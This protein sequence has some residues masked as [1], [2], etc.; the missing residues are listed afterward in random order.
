MRGRWLALIAAA[1]AAEPRA[2]FERVDLAPYPNPFGPDQPLWSEQPHRDHPFS[3]A[4]STDGAKLYV[5]LQGVE[6]EPGREVAIVDTE[7]L[8]VVGRIGVGSS[9]TG[10]EL[11][12]GGRFLVVTNRFSNYASVI[13]T[14]SDAVAL[15][16]EAPFYTTELVFSPDGRRAWLTNRWKDSVLRWD[17]DVGDGFRVTATNYQALP[18]DGPMGIP[19]GQNPRDLAISDDGR[20]LYVA[21]LTGEAVSLI[22]TASGRETVRYDLASPPADV[23]V[24]GDA[25]FVTNIGR[26]AGDLPD[27][28]NDGDEDGAPG[29]GTANVIF[30]DPQAQI[31]VLDATTLDV[32]HDYTSDT[33]CCR[34]Y[35][36]VDPDD[37]ERGLRLPAPDTWPPERAAFLPPK[38]TWIVAGALPEQMAVGGDSLWVAYSASNEVQR[39]AIADDGSLAPGPVLT[40]GMNPSDL[41]VSPDGRRVYV[42]ERL[43]EHVTVIDV[44]S[45]TTQRVPVGDVVAGEFP[46][47]DAELGEAFN[48]VTGPFTVDGDQACVGCHREGGNLQRHHT[49]PLQTDRVWGTRMIQAYRGA[50]DSR[51]WFLETAMDET[52]FFPV[53]NEFNRKEN[54]C[55]ELVDPLVWS[56]YPTAQACVAQPKL[57]GCN[58][59]LDCESD[60]PPEC[61]AR[62]YGSPHLTRNAAFLDAALRLFGRETTFGDGIW[63][64]APDGA[65][66]G[67]PLNF[68]GITRALGLFLLVRPRLLPNPNVQ[69]ATPAAER[70]RRLYES[71]ATG[72]AFCHPLPVTTVA[73]AP[74]FNPFDQEVQFPPVVS[75]R[76][77][78]VTRAN[79]DT[80]TA[81]FLQSFP[82]T[83]QD[84]DGAVRFGAPLLRGIWDRAT[85]FFH[86]GRAESLREALATPGHA[87]LEAGERGFNETDGVIDTHGGTSQLTPEELADLIAFLESL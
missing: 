63:I 70:G 22:D 47:T 18:W 35:R 25:V 6:D 50:M 36:E 56:K 21:A 33:L 69:L 46:A 5:T 16:V 65:R 51:P 71:S 84:A 78:P 11:H 44:E 67:V 83:V 73:T 45:Q 10:I 86:D 55:C 8:G 59:V 19:V 81:G 52:N 4:L 74:P 17:L 23:V 72:C 24:L 58:H 61:A 26:G 12:P 76:R 87:A 20:R 37:P 53:I 2:D 34:D 80:V 49:M 7:A 82:T 57:D 48:F 3:L 62:P 40:T 31:T 42:A 29:D 68:D 39:F 66:E 32:R 79:A 75:P 30:Q 77:N 1:C 54:F 15:D 85:R 9:P 14:A 13:D 28:G 43:G 64:E 41:V 27:D 38:E 60:P